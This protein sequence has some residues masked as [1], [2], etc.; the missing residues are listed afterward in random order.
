MVQKEKVGI[1]WDPRGFELDSVGKKSYLKATDG[2]T[3]YV[4]VPIRMLS[5]DT[6]EIHYP[7][8]QSPS[9]Y[10]GRLKRLSDWIK[11]GD[12]PIN[13]D[14][15]EHIIPKIATGKAGTLQK[16]QGKEAS[17]H[18]KEIIDEALTRPKG[19]K[20]K[21]FLYASEEHFDAYGRLLA[22]MSPQYSSKEL[23]AMPP[24]RRSTFNLRMVESGWAA[25]FLI[26]PSIP[27]H[28]D[29]VR[30]QT[31]GRAAYLGNRGI[32]QDPLTLIGY[33]FRMCV[34]LYRITKKLLNGA[35]MSS[36]ER[37]GWVSRY[38]ADMTTGKVYYPQD[39][40]KVK[41]YNRIFIW[42]KDVS[43]AVGKMNLIPA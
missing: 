40:Y 3:P 34:K 36:A 30:F 27:K 43:E 11:D 21:V 32:W 16:D 23:A 33:E 39:Y 6:P 1:F 4:S 10:D 37:Y 12:A 2:D 7:G 22:Y 15:G 38:C 35:K 28:A 24:E 41:P 25:P 42:P 13:K 17:D 5:I 29:L 26:Y 9:T 14:L 18:F 8:N 31:G 20:R 19:T